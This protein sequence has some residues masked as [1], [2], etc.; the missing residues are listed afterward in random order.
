MKLTYVGPF[1]PNPDVDGDKG[2]VWI[3]VDGLPLHLP[4]AEPVDVPDELG[5]K[6]LDEQPDNFT[7]GKAKPAAA[8]KPEEG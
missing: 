1:R 6:L 7:S 5:A 3:E 4:F 2:G 8:P